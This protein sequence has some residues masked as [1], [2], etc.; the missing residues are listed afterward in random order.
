MRVAIWD[1]DDRAVR[2]APSLG[3]RFSADGS[4]ERHTVVVTVRQPDE[5]G[6]R[7]PPTRVCGIAAGRPRS[8]T[9]RALCCSSWDGERTRSMILSWRRVM[10]S[11]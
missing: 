8:I 2:E 7:R 4:A 9:R 3:K 10:L 5:D 6:T 1:G 11:G